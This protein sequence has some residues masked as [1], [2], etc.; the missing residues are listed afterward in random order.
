[1]TMNRLFLLLTCLLLLFSPAFPAMGAEY[2]VGEGDVLKIKV[3]ENDD[4]NT[5]ARV[6]AD[7]TIRVPLLG[8]VKVGG[9]T[10]SEVALKLE[11]LFADGYL[12]NPQVD[13]FIEEHRS[14]NAIILGQIN[15][16]G[17]YEVRGVV[18]FLEFISK[19]GGLTA[20]AGNRATI[21][22]IKPDE[23]G[24][25]RVL[26]DLDRL[27][28]EGDAG[29]NI[30]IMDGD[31]IYISKADLFYVSG[32]VEDPDSYKLEPGMTV[33]Q[34]IAKAGGFTKIAAEGKVR[35]IRLVDGEKKILE[36]VK[37]DEPIKP[38]DVIVVPESFF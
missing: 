25:D 26:I 1:M 15:R 37:M 3:Y 24:R 31:N 6:S 2:T 10:V 11:K 23:N 34:G 18:S 27:I 22:H 17:Q 5:T 30:P 20:D 35:I 21:K 38:D 4:L 8:E 29:L 28:R 12:I 16:P 32:E 33:I 19:A 13:I 7:E 14:K 36:K 9:L